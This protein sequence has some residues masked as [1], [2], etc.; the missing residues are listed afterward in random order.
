MIR[1]L[2]VLKADLGTKSESVAC[3]V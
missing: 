3:Q 2:L 1:C